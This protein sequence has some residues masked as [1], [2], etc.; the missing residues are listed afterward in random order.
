[1]SK[2][3]QKEGGRSKTKGTEKEEGSQAAKAQGKG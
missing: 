2:K 1:M 3:G